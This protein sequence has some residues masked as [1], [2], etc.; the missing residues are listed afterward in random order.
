MSFLSPIRTEAELTQAVNTCRENNAAA[1]MVE[2]YKICTKKFG[3]AIKSSTKNYKLSQQIFEILDPENINTALT[4]EEYLAI[5]LKSTKPRNLDPMNQYLLVTR[6]M[7]MDMITTNISSLLKSHTTP[8]MTKPT[9]VQT[10]TLVSAIDKI[11]NETLLFANEKTTIE[12]PPRKR[13]S[14]DDNIYV[15]PKRSN[16]EQSSLSNS[17][18]DENIPP[19]EFSFDEFVNGTE[20]MFPHETK[21]FID[22]MFE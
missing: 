6:N 22:T 9:Q 16:S 12:S 17:L 8:Q 1:A 11:Y 21:Q 15:S 18:Y 14:T 19:P 7:F 20:N 2:L 13:R 5:A 3:T 4:E 10:D